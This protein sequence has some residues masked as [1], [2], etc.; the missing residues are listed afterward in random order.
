[1]AV[2]VIYLEMKFNLLKNRKKKRFGNSL[3]EIKQ[4]EVLQERDSVIKRIRTWVQKY[5]VQVYAF[6]LVIIVGILA[7]LVG[8]ARLWVIKESRKNFEDISAP[9]FND[10]DATITDYEIDYSTASL[11]G[12]YRV[13]R[14]DRDLLYGVTTAASELG[15]PSA[16]SRY[17]YDGYYKWTADDSTL[18]YNYLTDNVHFSGE[19]SS[20][21]YS[22]ESART[23]LSSLFGIN[24]EN[25]VLTTEDKGTSYA[26]WLF[27]YSIDGIDVVVGKEPSA[28]RVLADNAGNVYDIS[29][30]LISPFDSKKLKVLS[31]ASL[32]QSLFSLNKQ[33][34]AEI[35]VSDEVSYNSQPINLPRGH[36]ATE[37]T[38][39]VLYKSLT[40]TPFLVP[41]LELKGTLTTSDG[42][43]GPA[44]VLVDIVDW[45][46][47]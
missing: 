19:Y 35:Y 9:V 5:R 22:A 18:V 20:G 8:A 1:M 6:A 46:E 4:I 13:Y 36:F 14:L 25:L 39:V 47:A 33:V 37:E 2:A 42:A 31:I 16:P 3:S 7:Y 21:W 45:D 30:Y 10:S 23:G 28:V 40:E 38:A 26:M 11:E 32:E 17:E 27:D 43:S 44:T 12:S 34:H 41:A 29:M 15:F 24:S